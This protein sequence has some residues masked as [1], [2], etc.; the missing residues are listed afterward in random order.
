MDD[1]IR[2]LLDELRLTRDARGMTQEDLTRHIPWAASTIAMIES[3]RR[4]PPPGFWTA[5]DGALQ[6]GGALGRLAARLGSPQW[7]IEW[8]AA[9][10]GAV[11]LRW[12]EAL[13]VPGLLQ[14]EAYARAVL[15][16]AGLT[17]LE[18][19]ERRLATRL[20]RQAVLT[21]DDPVD[22]TAVLDENLLHRP[23]GG[24]T[25]MREQVDALVTAC[26][27]PHVRLHVVP[28]SVG[29]YPGLNGSFVIATA[30]DRAET[31]YLD[32]QLA[33]Q[34][35]D[36]ADDL[37]LLQRAWEAVRSQALPQ[38]QSTELIREVAE[39]WI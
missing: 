25:V 18:E 33:G 22:L 1:R 23:I 5:V 2:Y 21:R 31:G 39:K 4:K 20:A 17:N 26:A 24:P 27:L 37:A 3:G 29:A 12:Y 30:P 6:T 36:G 28:M 8:S 11:S 10:Q 34:V 13:V 35:V 7:F 38:Q 15:T 32:N 9:E 19:V 16:D 14:T